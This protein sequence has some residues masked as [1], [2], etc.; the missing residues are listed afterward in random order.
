MKY[1]NLGHL[2]DEIKGKIDSYDY[3]MAQVEVGLNEKQRLN[4]NTVM[5]LCNQ[6]GVIRT[7]CVDCLDRTNAVQNVFA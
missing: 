2:V 5:V 3:F 1:E 4:S 6:Q 7:N